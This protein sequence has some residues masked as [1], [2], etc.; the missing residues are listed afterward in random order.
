M[1]QNWAQAR[2][3][4]CET[5]NHTV[6][7]SI[8]KRSDTVKLRTENSHAKLWL[9]TP[10]PKSLRLFHTLLQLLKVILHYTNHNGS[11]APCPWQNFVQYTQQALSQSTNY[12]STWKDR[13]GKNQNKQKKRM[14]ITYSDLLHKTRANAKVSSG[15]SMKGLH[16]LFHKEKNQVEDKTQEARTELYS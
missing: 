15:C 10:L 14:E 12:R 4:G 2:V 11:A 3:F 9:T 13:L 8:K 7:S 1:F 16:T 6:L 5:Y